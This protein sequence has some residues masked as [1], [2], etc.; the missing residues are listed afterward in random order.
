MLKQHDP[1]E[2]W[3]FFKSLALNMSLRDRVLKW[4]PRADWQLLLGQ[5]VVELGGAGP[6]S[7][8]E[9]MNAQDR[10]G[11]LKRRFLSIV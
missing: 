4:E 9:R 7:D 2:S 3:R 5:G 10:E 6:G 1:A 11:E 8:L